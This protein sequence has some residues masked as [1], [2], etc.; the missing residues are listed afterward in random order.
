G[1]IVNAIRPGHV[2][3]IIPAFHTAKAAHDGKPRWANMDIA[4]IDHVAELAR[5]FPDARFVHIVRDG[6][7]VAL[8]HQDY[9][10]SEGNYLEIA[11]Q[12][13]AQ[14]LQAQRAASG[15]GERHL[16]ITFEA[17]VQAPEET[18]TKVCAHIG[19]PYDAAMLTYTQR[20]DAKIPAKRRGLWPEIGNSP[21]PSKTER[22]RQH[23]SNAARFVFEKH[24]ADALQAFGYDM[25]DPATNG[26]A[27]RAFA[28]QQELGR[29]HRYTRWR[30]RLGLP[31]KK[32]RGSE[33]A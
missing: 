2:E 27:P 7:D 20:V 33:S 18:L 5:W 4:S 9:A 19:L 24:A 23:M 16:Q 26:V 6:R 12:W 31:A 17:L 13:S 21:Q 22:W 32:V 14:T 8:S 3:D 1:K 29:G 25:S 10:F 30:K 28:L 11:E 15:I